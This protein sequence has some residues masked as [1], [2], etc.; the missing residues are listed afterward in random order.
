MF[1]GVENPK[2]QTD[3]EHE[4]EETEAANPKP[5]TPNLN[6]IPERKI[7]KSSR[8]RAREGTKQWAPKD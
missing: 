7:G 4:Q 1:K 8:T 6:K 3:N 2:L 5:Q